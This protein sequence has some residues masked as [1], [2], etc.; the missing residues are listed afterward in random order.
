MLVACVVLLLPNFIDTCQTLLYVCTTA[1]HR[2]KAACKAMQLY[3]H[4]TS[5]LLHRE[6]RQIK[7]E[8]YA[9]PDAKLDDKIKRLRQANYKLEYKQ[10]HNVCECWYKFLHD[11]HVIVRP[12]TSTHTHTLDLHLPALEGS[13]K[14][15]MQCR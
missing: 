2:C 11:M 7:K 9:N 14:S 3:K 6:L 13:L 8:I 5:T 15:A 12:H 4:K 1:D 10:R